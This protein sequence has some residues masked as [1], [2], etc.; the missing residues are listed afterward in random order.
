MSFWKKIN[1]AVDR[2]GVFLLLLAFLNMF[3]YFGA[4]LCL[5]LF[6][7]DIVTI[8]HKTGFVVDYE[9]QGI[10]WKSDRYT[11]ENENYTD[12][13]C[14]VS[15]EVDDK[16]FCAYLDDKKVRIVYE[17][18]S[19]SPWKKCDGEQYVVKSVEAVDGS[20]LTCEY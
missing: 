6:L 12:E 5:D 14:A 1:E 19:F 17:D 16:L 2:L 4:R 8:G 7:K 20:E 18:A 10:F 11:L 15:D 13:Y 3:L 9:E